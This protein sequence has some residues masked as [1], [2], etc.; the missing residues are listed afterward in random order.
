MTTKAFA[1][2]LAVGL[3]LPAFA[4]QALEDA[5][6]TGPLLAANAGTLPAGHV[7]FEPYLYDV[8]SPHSNAYRS[9]SYVEYGATDRLT[10]GAI[11]IFGY[12]AVDGG[13]N[14]V[15]PELSDLTLQAQ[16]RLTTWAKGGW[17]PTLSAVL[18]ES[19]PV[20]R[21]DRLGDHP[22]DG[23]GSGSYATTASLYSQSLFWM[24]NGRIVRMRF[25]V[26]E[27]VSAEAP[28]HG[29]SVYGTSEGFNGH[30][31]PGN[32]LYLNAA[33]EYSITQRWVLAFDAA[34]SDTANTRLIGP[35]F[36]ANLGP[37]RNFAFAPAIEYNWRE[38]IGVIVG[39][40]AIPAGR[41]TPGSITPAVALNLF[42]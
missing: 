20:G 30:V 31:R 33:W 13:P 36:I 5:W 22:N 29:V 18:K 21:Y 6:W 17:I 34:Y 37:S 3:A 15:G 9:R 35:D 4:E 10:V 16:Y 23:L 42:Y 27:T 26:E 14:S 2:L 7:L 25:N 12:N 28:V 19:L 1:F 8:I 39:M 40:R 41:N 38:D 32:N 24:P 11:P